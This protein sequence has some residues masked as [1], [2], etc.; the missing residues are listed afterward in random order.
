MT[1]QDLIARIGALFQ[2]AGAFVG[3]LDDDAAILPPVPA[4]AVRVLSTD[5][6]VEG[7]DFRRDLY[8]F[9]VA[10]GRALRQALSDLAAMGAVPVGFVWS[11]QV[12][13]SWERA[14][15]EAF[16]RGAA[17]V[18]AE[19][20]VA[21]AGGDVGKTSGPFAASM[22]VWGDVFGAPLSRRGAQPGDSVWVSRPVGGS[23][24]GLRLLLRETPGADFV[25]WRGGLGVSE[26]AA[27][28][29]HLEPVPAL[30]LGQQ[31]VGVATAALDVSDGLLLDLDRLALASGVSVVLD[32]LEAAVD[33][34][35]GATLADALGGGED[36]A[37]AFTLPAGVSPFT[38]PDAAP[39]AG[40]PRRL[41]RV[42][43]PASGGRL[44]QEHNDGQRT[45]LLPLGHDHFA[46]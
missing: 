17:V 13:K 1:E 46:P 21:L 2:E 20:G 37:L 4:G 25:H 14:D 12:P 19:H 39:G 23:A 41:G 15:V 27:V 10:G 26:A 44:W 9:S 40:R 8:P 35:A 6:V 45:A 34:E 5:A 36:F 30:A 18:A 32:Q 24:C 31:L 42:E 11:L 29:A 16:C 43:A 3:P 7:V 33:E 22:T 28:R 38:D